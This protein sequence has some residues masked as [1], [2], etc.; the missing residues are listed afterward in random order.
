MSVQSKFVPKSCIAV[1]SMA[2]MLASCSNDEVQE[3]YQGNEIAFSSRVSRAIPIEKPA[4]LKS[5]KVYAD[6]KGYTDMFINGVEATPETE[7]SSTYVLPTSYYWP[8]DVESIRFWAYGP[9]GTDGI[10]ITPNI[11]ADGQGFEAYK[12]VSDLKIGGKNHKDFVVAYANVSRKEATGMLVPLTFNHALCQVL[13]NAKKGTDESKRVYVKGA[14]IMNAKASGTLSFND[15]DATLTNHMLWSAGTE[16]ASYGVELNSETMLTH[17]GVTLIGG[18]DDS[19]LMLIPQEYKYS[20]GETI[21]TK[22]TG[23]YIMVLC[24]V[25]A[26]HPGTTHPGGGSTVVEGSN[27]V[28]QLFPVNKD[29]TFVKEEYGYTCVP[30]DIDWKPG[31]KYVYNL[32]FCGNGSGA[33]V[34]PPKPGTGF[35]SDNVVDRPVKDPD[36]EDSVGKDVGEPVLD[37]PIRFTV[38]VDKWTDS[39]QNTPMQ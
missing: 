4:D 28:H 2:L 9:T 6:A 35:P 32:E 5:F 34:Y 8:A 17:A 38:D 23:A 22:E 3:I 21:K 39:T 27:H 14:W 1:T 12:P 36:D 16:L 29:G 15:Q 24:R 31:M 26:I 13:V 10:N 25:E 20:E 33:G 37:D 18:S 7:G 19:N 30:I 11:T